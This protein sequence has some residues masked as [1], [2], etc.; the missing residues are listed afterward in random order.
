MTASRRAER[1]LRPDLVCY[2]HLRWDLV[3]QRPN[4]LMSRAARD[5][6][7]FYVEEPVWSDAPGR[8]EVFPARE[9]LFI[10]RPHMRLG[11]DEDARLLALRQLVD[12]LLSEHRI[13]AH[14]S[15]YYTSM[16]VRYTR[17]TRPALTVYDV[18][19]DLTYFHG[20][21]A[22]APLLAATEAELFARADIVFT[23][24]YS[25]HEAKRARHPNVHL[26]PSA[27]DAAHFAQAREGLQQPEEQRGLPRPRLGF[28]GV[29]DERMDL[30]LVEAVADLRPD[31]QFVFVGPVVKIEE[32][33]LPRRANL[34]WVGPRAYEELPAYIAGWDVALMPFARNAATRFIS[35]TKTPEYLAA[36][37]PV[38]STSIADVVRPYAELGLVRIA[39]EPE[40]FVAAAEAAM[41]EA[42]PDRQ[43]DADRFLKTISWDRTWAAMD[44]LMTEALAARGMP[45]PVA[46]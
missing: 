13:G 23:G 7:V 28:F 34:H 39:D 40:S 17:H 27:V 37:R 45:Q 35:P 20:A 2:S 21:A 3:F 38:V 31:W 44:A 11:L 15:W 6:R 25:L 12:E 30:P 24:G 1:D 4:H 43:R 32:E 33:A 19:D 36:G 10:V 22:A 5:R 41:R 46:S 29:I 26:F 14:I 9:R 42:S 18:M 8:L 16:A